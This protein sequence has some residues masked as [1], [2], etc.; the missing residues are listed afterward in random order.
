MRQPTDPRD[1]LLQANET[2]NE[3][4]LDPRHDD[5]GPDFSEEFRAFCP[6]SDRDYGPLER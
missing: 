1:R 4:L 2:E 3:A 6:V 5:E